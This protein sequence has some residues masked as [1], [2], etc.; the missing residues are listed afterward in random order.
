MSA[1][2]EKNVYCFVSGK[3]WKL[4]LAE[5]ASYLDARGIKFE[6]SEFSRSF[7]T[8]KTETALDASVIDDLGGTLKITQVAAFVPTKRIT[9]AFLE[10][11]KQVKKQLKFDLP[12]DALADKMP[13]A[14]SGK[15]VFGVSVYWAD[16]FFKPAARAAQRFLGSA[17][18]DELKE[19]DKK[20]RFMGFP[21][22]RQNPQLTP[23]EVLKQ[24]LLENHAEILMCIGK[25]ETAVGTTMAVHNPFEFQKRDLDKPAQRKIFG[26][27]PRVSRIMV[28]LT[29]CTPEKV[30]LDPFCGVGNILQEALLANARVIGVDI[31]R[32]CVE[33]AKRNLS[34]LTREYSLADADY[35]VV[36]GDARDLRRKI[37]EVDC[38]ATEPDLGPALREVPT[39]PYAEKIVSSLKPLFEDF[40]VSAHG[41]MWAGSYLAVVTP[42]IKTRSGKAVTMNIG[43]MAQSVG[44]KAVAPFREVAFVGDAADFPLRDLTSF[45]DVDERHKIG[46]EISI[47]QKP[48]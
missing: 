32:W 29:R 17:L 15:A 44:F 42:Y 47:F 30:F 33:A 8:I 9:D 34:W 40:L 43:K 36:Q 27:S 25:T 4:S 13:R 5:I 21:R 12:L 10:E 7:F 23:V 31:N 45:V 11:D 1:Q 28:N 2:T 37:R 16:P 48:Q 14:A 19:Q 39:E 20:A 3:N 38:V 35:A 26:I 22:D 6:V 18:K 46:R 24:G 41:V